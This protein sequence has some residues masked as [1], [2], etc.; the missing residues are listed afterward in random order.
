MVMSCWL[1]TLALP[2]QAQFFQDDFERADGAV[3]GWTVNAGTW[4][5]QSGGL[6]GGPPPLGFEQQIY[7]GSP[8]LVLPETYRITLD[9]EWIQPNPPGGVGRHAAFSSAR[10]TSPLAGP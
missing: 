7:A 6:V 4:A 2:V 8:A 3:G 5:I 9:V 1:L 10:R